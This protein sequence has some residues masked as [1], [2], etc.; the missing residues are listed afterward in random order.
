MTVK[1]S[2]LGT[3][4]SAEASEPLGHVTSLGQLVRGRGVTGAVRVGAG[5]YQVTFDRNIQGCAYVASLGDPS[6]AGPP[7]GSAG[8]SPAGHQPATP[9]RYAP[10]GANGDGREPPFHLIVSC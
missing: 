4:P 1:E 3:V 2:R 10:D 9:S 8:T 5:R 6:V 7:Y